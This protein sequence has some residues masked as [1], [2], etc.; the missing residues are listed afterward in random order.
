MV[1]NLI[2]LYPST[3]TEFTTNG[4]GVLSEISK[5]EVTEELNGSFEMEIECPIS[6]KYYPDIQLRSII[7]SKP[8]KYDEPQAFRVYFISKPFNGYVT[9]KAQHISYDLSGYPT[10]RFTAATATAAMA[11]VKSNSILPVDS[12][13]FTFSTNLDV[14]ADIT[15]EKPVSMRAVLGDGDNSL[16]NIYGG[17]FRFNNFN[18]SLLTNRGSDNGVVI[19]YG[20]NL[21]DITQEENNS[22]VYTGVYPYAVYT[23]DVEVDENTPI[24]EPIT[25]TQIIDISEGDKIIH[26]SGTYDYEKIYPYDV[27][28]D[29]QNTN[30]W[31]RNYPDNEELTAAANK[32]ITDKN[33]GIPKVSLTVSFQPLVDAQ[34]Y[35]NLESLE[36]IYLGDTVTVLFEKLGVD[37]KAKCN[38]TTFDVLHNRYVSI[39]LGESSSNLADGIAST[40][41]VYKEEIMKRSTV[42]IAREA[43]EQA[44]SIVTGNSGG[45]VVIHDS[46]DDGKP[47]EILIMDNVDISRAVNV[48]RWNQSGLMHSSS[49]YNGTYANAAITYDGEID[50]NT[51]KTGT[52]QIGTD[53]DTFIYISDESLHSEGINPT[54]SDNQGH[55]A[56]NSH[57]AVEIQNGTITFNDTST[58]PNDNLYFTNPLAH[59]MLQAFGSNNNPGLCVLLR[60]DSSKFVIGRRDGYTN[61]NF[62]EFIKKEFDR[63]SLNNNDKKD[64]ICPTTKIDI[65]DSNFNFREVNNGVPTEGVTGTYTINNIRYRFN[66]GILMEVT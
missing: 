49:G 60:N 51:I 30:E 22:D 45:Y 37:T 21:T 10:G 31:V 3:A 66:K 33:L 39:E 18:I 59:L 4:I 5:C 12:I 35:E 63:S 61:T 54:Y 11:A 50:A 27:S 28:S 16:L 40:N 7:L 34:D 2:I 24:N 53:D 20:K 13:P 8:N 17:E 57:N 15:N 56:I 44:A 32:Y 14:T 29:W 47:D 23:P 25:E 1:D 62:I 38:K 48:W 52:L 6:A 46:D 58:D 43:G 55:I 42:S 64:V 9:I 65:D 41:S 19:R 36:R 26:C